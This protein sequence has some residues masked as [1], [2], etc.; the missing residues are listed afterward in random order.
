MDHQNTA[1][2]QISWQLK[3]K[4]LFIFK[5]NEHDISF[6]SPSTSPNVYHKTNNSE[7][8]TR[9]R[10]EPIIRLW[11]F[12]YSYS[13]C[14]HSWFTLLFCLVLWFPHFNVSQE[15][16]SISWWGW[17]VRNIKIL[18]Q[19]LFLQ[20]YTLLVKLLVNAWLCDLFRYPSKQIA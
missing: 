2:R 3:P 10:A 19:S 18:H 9:F 14:R 12:I 20:F 13:K 15:I 4:L 11:S 17:E 16:S 7:K 8:F 1:H 6:P 5:E